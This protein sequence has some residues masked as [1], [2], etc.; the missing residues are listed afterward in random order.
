M[1]ISYPIISDHIRSYQ[2]ISQLR[3]NMVKLALL[4]VAFAAV[5]LAQ[6]ER[7][8]EGWCNQRASSCNNGNCKLTCNGEVKK[9]SCAQPKSISIYK[10]G[11]GKTIFECGSSSFQQIPPMKPF[12]PMQWAEWGKFT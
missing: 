5:H 3:F 6:G 1:G 10:D 8:W 4:L 7:L 11:N 9:A 2:I 12:P